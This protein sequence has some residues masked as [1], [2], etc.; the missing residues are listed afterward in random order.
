MLYIFFPGPGSSEYTEQLDSSQIRDPTTPLSLRVLACQCL[1][2]IVSSRDSSSISVMGKFSW[3]QSDLGVARGHYMGL[4]PC[5]LRSSTS[6]IQSLATSIPTAR[7]DI[8]AERSTTRT[9]PSLLRISES[10][11]GNEQSDSDSVSVDQDGK[12]LMTPRRRNLIAQSLKILPESATVPAVSLNE[13]DSGSSQYTKSATPCPIIDDIASCLDR[14][15]WIE[16][17][18]M[19]TMSLITTTNALPAFAENGL[20][21]L[22]VSV[23]KL[24]PVHVPASEPESDQFTRLLALRRTYVTGLLTQLL[25][26]A[27]SSHVPSMSM[28]TE[29]KGF[30]VAL[31]RLADELDELDVT[32]YFLSGAA[33][34][35]EPKGLDSVQ[36]KELDD[37]DMDG[38]EDEEVQDG[39]GKLLSTPPVSRENKEP[40][41]PA[42]GR[43]LVSI[44][45]AK[46]ISAAST[47][48]LHSLL[49]LCTFYLQQSSQGKILREKLFSQILLKLFSNMKTLNPSVS[50]SSFILFSDVINNDP[51]ILSHLIGNGVAESCLEASILHNTVCD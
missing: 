17:V 18:L 12:P 21:S 27:I 39:E 45:D 13:N 34:S 29:V 15:S 30:E 26:Q 28:F 9:L 44:M 42:G 48:M 51:S 6:F 49:T 23:L 43:L 14:L 33:D 40:D 41:Q 25:E 31:H 22:L 46:H 19:L 4:L 5:L 37:V 24:P 8:N 47:I 50:A 32:S 20:V 10:L 11:N 38:D 16:H 36:H 35:S 3:L 1:T 7:P 2:A